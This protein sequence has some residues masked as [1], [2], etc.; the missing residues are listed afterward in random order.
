MWD[1]LNSNKSAVAFILFLLGQVVLALVWGA[2][3]DQRVT[4]LAAKV[5]ILDSVGGRQVHSTLA[6]ITNLERSLDKIGDMLT[7]LPVIDE[8]ITMIKEQLVE[9]NQQT[10]A[11]YKLQSENSTPVDIDNLPE[12]LKAPLQKLQKEIEEEV[13]NGK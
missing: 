12:R 6:R 2:H 5:E 1:M 8:R 7:K 3:L 13:K 4:E 10:K 9:M 11:V